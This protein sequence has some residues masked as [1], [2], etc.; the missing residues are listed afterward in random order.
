LTLALLK[1]STNLWYLDEI[2]NKLTKSLLIFTI[3]LVKLVEQSIRQKV[4]DSII[5]AVYMYNHILIM[6]IWCYRRE[7]SDLELKEL[8]ILNRSSLEE[9][10][11]LCKFS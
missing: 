5:C 1:V 9:H 8:R 7:S 6:M 3:L 10:I 4:V 2:M 11:F